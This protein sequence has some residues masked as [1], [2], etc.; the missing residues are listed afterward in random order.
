MKPRWG[1]GSWAI[2]VSQGS[3]YA[4]TLGYA[5]GRF[6]RLTKEAQVVR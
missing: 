1:M 2:L 6:Q 4:A 3:R 5:M